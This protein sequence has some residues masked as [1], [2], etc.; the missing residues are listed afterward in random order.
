MEAVTQVD[1][2]YQKKTHRGG[3]GL[4]LHVAGLRPASMACSRISPTTGR[5]THL[6]IHSWAEASPGHSS[7]K[8]R[9]LTGDTIIAEHLPALRVA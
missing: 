6:Q 5:V 3:I 4:V 8:G 7:K 9:G 1:M 2:S